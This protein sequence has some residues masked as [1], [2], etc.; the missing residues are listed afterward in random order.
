ME[1]SDTI[2]DDML[3]KIAVVLGG[4][5]EAIKNF[6]DDAVINII[7]NSFSDF[8]DNASAINY[9]CELNFNPIDKIM[10]LYDKKL[11]LLERL[12]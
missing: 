7:S 8:K 5:A 10:Q 6:N 1:Q 9:N 3:E 4:S 11:E 2:E 12:L